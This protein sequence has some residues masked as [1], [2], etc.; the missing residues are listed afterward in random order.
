M[1]YSSIR[2]YHLETLSKVYPGSLYVTSL[3]YLY[4]YNYLK[5]K[6]LIKTTK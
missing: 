6:S 3:S 1:L 4:V 2:G 5:T